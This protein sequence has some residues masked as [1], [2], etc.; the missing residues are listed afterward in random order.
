MEFKELYTRNNIE[1]G[2]QKLYGPFPLIKEY[3]FSTNKKGMKVIIP[4]KYNNYTDAFYAEVDGYAFFY[5]VLHYGELLYNILKLYIN[6]L[7]KSWSIPNTFEDS[8]IQVVSEQTIN[9]CFD[10]IENICIEFLHK[11]TFGFIPQKY[12]PVSYKLNQGI[13]LFPLINHILIIF[14]FYTAFENLS[15]GYE[16]F[17]EL[18][19]SLSIKQDTSDSDILNI[20]IDY[21][22][23]YSQPYYNITSFHLSFLRIDNNIIPITITYN[24]FAFAFEVLQNIVSTRSFY[25][26]DKY[27]DLHTYIGFR[28][29][30]RCLKNIV[31]LDMDRQNFLSAPKYR[32]VYCDDCKKELKR[33]ASNKYEHSIR[34]L[35]DKLKNNVDNCNSKLANEIRNLK[36]K[37]K[38]TKSHL[39]RLYTEYLNNLKNK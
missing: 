13:P 21:I 19:E 29:C 2:C 7:R 22:N 31:D 27:N 16:S 30:A 26:F 18:Y 3:K 1:Y 35:Y 25:S 8:T 33:I 17:R 37:D 28:K 38:E 4:I 14:I 23:I 9:K 24:L 5:D 36:P 39:Q 6:P 34:E 12:F 10:K 20:I 11:Y 15:S 32:K